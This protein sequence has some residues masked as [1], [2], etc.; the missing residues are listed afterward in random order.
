MAKGRPWKVFIG[1][2]DGL[3]YEVFA[4]N[5]KIDKVAIEHGILRRVHG[6][7]YDLISLDNQIVIEDITH[8]MTQEEEA[9][10]RVVSWALRHGAKLEF[11]VEQLNKAEGD[12]TSFAKAIARTFKK[13]LKY[14]NNSNNSMCPNCNS[15]GS[16]VSESGCTSC[17]QCGYS[18]CD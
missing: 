16:L 17:K 13:Y 1:L 14:G 2:L 5:G 7:R 3:P 12:I 10:T 6:G 4:V 15:S 18:K 11:G 8:N 9:F